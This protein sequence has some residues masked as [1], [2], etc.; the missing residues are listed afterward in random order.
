MK[1]FLSLVVLGLLIAEPVLTAGHSKAKQIAK[2]KASSPS[3]DRA[4]PKKKMHRKL[5]NRLQKSMQAPNSEVEVIDDPVSEIPK[6]QSAV[7]EVEVETEAEA[8]KNAEAKTE[9]KTKTKSTKK[10]K[11]MATQDDTNTAVTLILNMDDDL[12][13]LPHT[14]QP[15]SS[16]DAS[17]PLASTCVSESE[18]WEPNILGP[19]AFEVLEYV[20]AVPVPRNVSVTE[21]IETGVLPSVI[22]RCVNPMDMAL[23]FDDGLHSATASVLDILKAESIPATFFIQGNSLECALVGDHM[24]QS[25]LKRMLAEGHTIASHSYSHPDF[26]TYWPDGIKCEMDKTADLFRGLIGKAPRFMRPPYGNADP[27]TQ[28]VLHDLGYF[29]IRWNLDTNDWRYPD[30]DKRIAHNFENGASSLS[31]KKLPAIVLMHDVYTNIPAYLTEIIKRARHLGYN[32]VNMEQCLGGID[33]YFAEKA[34]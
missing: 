27:K 23:T 30:D 4:P 31:R 20:P 29:I 12:S 22:T 14:S 10:T 17:E 28:A 18:D 3:R 25:L 26:N 34:D 32:F 15:S 19:E 7:S 21:S 5:H 9:K 1:A 8:D 13:I 16:P 33:P 11:P 24:P 2:K 6:A